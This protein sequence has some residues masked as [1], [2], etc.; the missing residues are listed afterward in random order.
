MTRATIIRKNAAALAPAPHLLDYAGERRQ[1]SW[2]AVRAELAASRAAGS[3]GARL[4]A[5]LDSESTLQ[6]P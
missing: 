3:T 1:F 4:A 5:G 6:F 2:D